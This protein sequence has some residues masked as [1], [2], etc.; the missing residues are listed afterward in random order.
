VKPPADLWDDLFPS[1]P[2]LHPP[3]SRIMLRLISYDI[4]DPKRLHRVAEACLDFG[5][6]VQK[7][8]FECWLD[9]PDFERLWAELNGLIDPATDRLLAYSLDKTAA[10]ARRT[11]GEKMTIT[12]RP[13]VYIF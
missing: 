9:T 10:R 5:V 4:T 3:G 8:I 2:H 13:V 11:A 7:S 6:R 12:E 1:S